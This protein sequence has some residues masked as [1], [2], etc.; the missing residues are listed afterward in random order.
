MI[1][2]H[3]IA[4]PL[5]LSLS[6]C[7]APPPPIV[8]ET[9]F[10]DVRANSKRKAGEVAQLLER[11]APEVQS[12]LPGSQDR[13]I[14]VWVQQELK[15]YRFNKRPESVRGFT[16]LSDEFSAKRI[17][18]QESGQSPWYLSHELV[19]A[20]IGPD[21]KTLP[22]IM[23]E[24]LGDVVAEKLNPEY[25]N[26]IRAH[27]LL[28]AG[29]F[30]SGLEFDVAYQLPRDDLSSW[31]WP[32]ERRTARLRTLEALPF[33]IVEE[34]F[35]TSRADL[36]GR[37]P[38]IPESFYGLAWLF[39]SRIAEREG[40]TGLYDLCLKA[41]A[42]GYELIPFPWLL[43]A[44]EIDRDDFGP[45]FLG[46]CFGKNEFLTAIYLQPEAFGWAALEALKPLQNRISEENL[47]SDVRPA[48]VLKDGSRI[49]MGFVGPVKGRIMR[50]W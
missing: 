4:L 27:R 6:A 50:E 7:L 28:N 34:L 44:A 13:Q 30:T 47:F 38:E 22:G 33:V 37:W 43:E 9:P 18:L 46:A 3:R 49:P 5:A 35:K 16:L 8:V 11:L 20:L 21:W 31:W 45:D 39:V 19:H 26:H 29:A 12:I 10:G 42:E 40:I 14:D 36:H 2:F 41:E 17:H 25:E 15:V 48:F 32:E 24:G 23:E 1:P